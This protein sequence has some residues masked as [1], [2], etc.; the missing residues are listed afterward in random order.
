LFRV[1]QGCGV[2]INPIR[3]LVA[4][5]GCRVPRPVAEPRCVAR[6]CAVRSPR[7]ALNDPKTPKTT[8]LR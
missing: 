2:F 5:G 8:T 3:Q 7:V 1:F 4:S 6:H